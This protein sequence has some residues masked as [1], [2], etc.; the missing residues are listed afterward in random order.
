MNHADESL[1]QAK[2]KDGHSALDLANKRKV[3]TKRSLHDI[4]SRSYKKAS[5]EER[6]ENN[7]EKG[8]RQKR[9]KGG[10]GTALVADALS[11]WGCDPKGS[12][13][14]WEESEQWATAAVDEW[15]EWA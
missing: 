10:K 6:P 2:T 3:G 8:R 7:P 15:D 12:G 14:S 11:S 13:F 1:V 4:V 5:V 9:I